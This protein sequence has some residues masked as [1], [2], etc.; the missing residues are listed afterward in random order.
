MAWATPWTATTGQVVTAA[1]MNAIRDN[2]R[3][4][5]GLDGGVTLENA[6]SVNY[7]AGAASG[8][9]LN[10]RNTTASAQY[11]GIINLQDNAGANRGQ[12]LAYGDQDGFRFFGGGPGRVVIWGAA[13][14]NSATPINVIPAGVVRRWAAWGVAYHSGGSGAFNAVNNVP[15]VQTTLYTDGT[16]ILVAQA[17]S[18]VLQ[19]YRS[20]GSASFDVIL[21]VAYQ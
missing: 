15:N 16:N 5:K 14:I 3:F 2:L 9:T 18:G 8:S 4:L 21:F 10:L 13:G 7:A 11:A 12:L 6:L 17:S 19:V 20:G 1:Q